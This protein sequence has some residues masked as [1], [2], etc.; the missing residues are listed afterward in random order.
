MG[1]QLLVSADF[2]PGG[3]KTRD[4]LLSRLVG[5]G[6]ATRLHAKDAQMFGADSLG[7]IRTRLNWV[8]APEQADAVLEQ[9]GVLHERFALS[10]DN[11]V[12]LCGM[13]GSSLGPKML[14]QVSRGALNVLDSTHPG[15]VASALGDV[16]RALFVMSS[17][18]GTTVETI[19]H[20]SVIE[21]T[22]RESGVEPADRILVI[23]DPETPLAQY[24]AQQGY[25]TILGDPNVGGRFSV[26]T[27]FGLIPAALAGGDV[28]PIVASAR[29]A[30]E[31]LFR[32]S[33]DNPALQLAAGILAQG[34]PFYLEEDPREPGLS[35]W[36]EQLVAESTGKRGVGVLPIL[37]DGA[38]DPTNRSRMRVRL[39]GSLGAKLLC[40][41]IAT[42]AMSW[43]LGVN[44][45]NQP[46]VERSKQAARDLLSSMA[47]ADAGGEQEHMLTASGVVTEL[48]RVIPTD[49]YIALQ[50]FGSYSGRAE[51]QALRSEMEVRLSVPVTFGIGPAYLHST[52]QLHKGGPRTGVFVQIVEPWDQ[53]VD[54]PGQS[55]TFGELME[56]QARGDAAVLREIGRPVLRTGAPLS[57]LLEAVTSQL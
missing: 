39:T 44:P 57:E 25:E 31:T 49:G 23:T 27:A 15:D 13:G 11:M 10:P 16:D 14:A 34:F 47:L 12:L 50:Y 19:S 5:A 1:E 43:L 6:F 2:A 3:R 54:I 45:F 7:E 40:W 42:A 55:H 21:R 32:D 48:Q 41:E 53:D 26:L 18:S 28:Q 22:L 4:E 36:I 20:L 8:S 9:V 37:L 33:I 46:D 52:G 24:A 17:K 51:L 35:A 29:A 56:A 30:Q 38:A